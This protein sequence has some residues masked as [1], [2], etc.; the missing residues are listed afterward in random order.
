MPSGYC[1]TVALRLYSKEATIY[2]RDMV[3]A[4]ETNP[5]YIP[6]TSQPAAVIPYQEGKVRIF[7]M[8]TALVAN[9]FDHTHLRLPT[10]LANDTDVPELPNH[11]HQWLVE[12]D[13][14]RALYEDGDARAADFLKIY[15]S[16]LGGGQ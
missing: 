13:L 5:L 2:G 4:L 8:P 15:L 10:T 7:P 1:K 14:Y 16:H 11:T 6:T 9:G 3:A 12:Y